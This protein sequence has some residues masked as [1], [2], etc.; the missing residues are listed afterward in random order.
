[1][2][3]APQYQQLQNLGQ[4][5]QQAVQGRPEQQGMGKIS[6][7]ESMVHTMDMPQSASMVMP[8]NQQSNMQS[9][10]AA[11]NAQ[12]AQQQAQKFGANQGFQS[13]QNDPYKTL[14]LPMGRGFR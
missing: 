5:Q 12:Q 7:N 9:M 11:M 1:M 10:L 4:A 13:E 14:R 8:K 6:G 3:A 2:R